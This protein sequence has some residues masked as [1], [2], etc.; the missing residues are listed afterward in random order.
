MFALL[1]LATTHVGRWA[2]LDFFIAQLFDVVPPKGKSDVS[3]S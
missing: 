2:G 3:Q 1:T